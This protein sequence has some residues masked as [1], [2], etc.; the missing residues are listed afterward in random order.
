MTR[1]SLARLAAPLA[2]VLTL[3]GCALHS[4]SIAD[5]KYN[6]GRY[7]DRTVSVEGVV[8]SS[9]GVPLVPFKFYKVD[10]GRLCAWTA[11]Y[12]V[13]RS[14]IRKP[15]RDPTINL[16]LAGLGQTYPSVPRSL[17]AGYETPELEPR[18]LAPRRTINRKLNRRS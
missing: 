3:A 11:L 6:P 4:P 14:R 17:S 15:M 7:Q 18:G 2:L 8:T 10:D 13:S 9:W 16:S 5:I 12:L 1:T